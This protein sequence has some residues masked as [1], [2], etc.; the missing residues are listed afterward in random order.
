[1]SSR[2]GI[3]TQLKT[4]FRIVLN[5]LNLGKLNEIKNVTH[6]ASSKHSNGSYHQHRCIGDCRSQNSVSLMKSEKI[7]LY[8]GMLSTPLCTAYLGKMW[9]ENENI[10]I[11]PN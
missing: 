6:P 3:P 4:G 1:M 11:V 9:E 10:P 7:W 5:L 2:T 8:V